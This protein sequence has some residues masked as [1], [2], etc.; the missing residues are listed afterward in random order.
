LIPDA[1]TPYYP[2][3]LKKPLNRSGNVFR[4]LLSRLRLRSGKAKSGRVDRESVE[5][6][7]GFPI[8]DLSHYERA[9]THR[10]LLRS[11]PSPHLTSNE[12]LEYLGDAVLGMMVAEHL[13]KQFPD[14]DEGYLTRLRAKLVNRRALAECALEL[15]LGE[16]ILMSKAI[17]ETTGRTSE[18][19]LSDAFEAVIGAIYLDLGMEA[20][21]LFVNRTVLHRVNLAELARQ[22][23]N[24]KS[25]LLEFAQARRWPQPDYLVVEEIGPSHDKTFRVEVQLSGRSLGEGTAKSKKEAEQIAASRAL[26]ALAEQD[27]AEA[28]ESP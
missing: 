7:V 26:T 16:Q 9:L 14:R 19:I 21:R 22:R 18:S 4:R 5:R 1:P 17:A 15:G 27:A 20:A 11:D 28:E 25:H 3:G 10:S 24:F 2:T 12:R 23:V 6:L 13:F 8:Q